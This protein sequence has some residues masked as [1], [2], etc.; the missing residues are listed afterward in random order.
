MSG[1]M[2]DD[3]EMDDPELQ[4][5]LALS[6]MEHEQQVCTRVREREGWMDT[7]LEAL[8][9]RAA[10]LCRSCGVAVCSLDPPCF[11][12]EHRVRGGGSEAVPRARSLEKTPQ[13]GGWHGALCPLRFARH[14]LS[15][16]I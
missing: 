10:E 13:K 5:A 8:V 1:S 15:L 3:M 14:L 12:S 16:A 6:M 7:T 9:L 4:M 11:L 2:D